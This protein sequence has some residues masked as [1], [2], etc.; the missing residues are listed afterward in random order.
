MRPAR[1]L[2]ALTLSL[3]AVPAASGNTPCVFAINYPG[4]ERTSLEFF[5]FPCEKVGKVILLILR[6]DL[7]VGAATPPWEE[8]KCGY[9]VYTGEEV[10][11]IHRNRMLASSVGAAPVLLVVVGIGFW[12]R[13]RR[14]KHTGQSPEMGKG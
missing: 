9:Y 12:W 11:R 7:D 10:E 2:L 3:T 6:K 1:L 5:L 14:R 4:V 8:K 13:A